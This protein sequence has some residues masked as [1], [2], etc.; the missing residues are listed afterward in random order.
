MSRNASTRGGAVHMAERDTSGWVD[1]LRAALPFF[2]TT[3]DVCGLLRFA[4]GDGLACARYW[5]RAHRVPFVQAGRRKVY[6]REDV[7]SALSAAVEHP[8]A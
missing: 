6:R 2:L 7:I 8:V 3:A 4:G 5:L 1:E